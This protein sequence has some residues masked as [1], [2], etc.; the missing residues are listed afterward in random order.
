MAAVC[1]AIYIFVVHYSRYGNWIFAMGG[2]SVSAR[3]VGIPT[4]PLTIVLFVAVGHQRR[5]RRHVPGDP[6]QLRAS[7]G[8]QSFIFNSII[9]V[10]VGGVLLTGGFGSVVGIFLGT[11]TFAVVNQGIYYTRLRRATGRA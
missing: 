3:N 4:K 6:L 8:R 11:L 5:L 1:A 9:A 10:V 2:D 7:V